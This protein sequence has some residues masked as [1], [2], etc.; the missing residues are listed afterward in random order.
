MSREYN[1]TTSSSDGGTVD[2]GVDRGATVRVIACFVA[3]ALALVAALVALSVRA[4]RRKLL[5]AASAGVGGNRASA[6]AAAATETNGWFAVR[7]PDGREHQVAVRCD[8]DAD[9]A[10]DDAV[11]VVVAVDA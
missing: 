10:P 7:G 5:A 11:V 9:D 1:A 4:R 3:G 8:D 2:S 6:S